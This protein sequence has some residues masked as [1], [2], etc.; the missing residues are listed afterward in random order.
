[1]SAAKDW[2]AS[3]EPACPHCGHT[4]FS[5]SFETV[6]LPAAVQEVQAGQLDAL[7]RRKKVIRLENFS[8]ATPGDTARISFR[9][10]MR[11]Y[12]GQPGKPEPDEG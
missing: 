11:A 8:A 1:V 12:T 6:R 3:K 10:R 7:G 9:E 5:I 2:S 4:Q